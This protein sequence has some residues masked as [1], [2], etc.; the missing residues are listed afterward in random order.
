MV[1]MDKFESLK[2]MINTAVKIDNRQYNS[3]VNKKTWFKPIL[4]NK[5]QFKK[6]SYGARCYKKNEKKNCYVC[7]KLGHLKRNCSKKIVGR[8]D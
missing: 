6:R 5:P 7:G 4:N 3:F 2:N 1:A 8:M